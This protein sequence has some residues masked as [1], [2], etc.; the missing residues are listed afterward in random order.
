MAYVIDYTSEDLSAI[1]IDVAGHGGVELKNY[2][3][4]LVLAFVA[5]ILLGV[6]VRANHAFSR[7]TGEQ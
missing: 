1:A 7:L 6:W 2:I 4:I 3:T 5:I